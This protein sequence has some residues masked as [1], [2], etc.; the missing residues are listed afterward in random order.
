M[1]EIRVD[2][3]TVC[4]QSPCSVTKLA[5]GAH[6]VDVTAPGYVKSATRAAEIEY[7]PDCRGRVLAH[8]RHHG[9]ARGSARPELAAVRG[10]QGSR[11]L[12]RQR[13]RRRSRLAF[14]P[15]RGQRPLPAIRA[16]VNARPGRDQDARTQASGGQGRSPGSSPERTLKGAHVWLV[17]GSDPKV[18]LALPTVKEV[19]VDQGCRVEASKRGIR[20]REPGPLLRGRQCGEVIHRRSRQGQPRRRPRPGVVT[21]RE[22][23]EPAR[24]ATRPAAAP[25]PAVAKPAP[26][27][28]AGETCRGRGSPGHHQ[29][30][31]HARV[32]GDRG[33]NA[34]GQT[35]ARVYGAGRQSHGGVHPPP[36][37]PKIGDG[38]GQGR[39]KHR[40]SGQV[41][42]SP[43][44][45]RHHGK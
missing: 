33:R 45:R 19:A 34:A 15:H 28:A 35:P 39:R 2:D 21:R 12:A 4:R 9:R 16:A 3:R 24:K 41:R 17:C 10:W 7:R 38:Q 6:T 11:S 43:R 23:C 5:V 18:E 42:L 44:G 40:G 22:S 1:L 26:P 25:K 13:G 37:G 29:H 32:F 8:A 14:D 30:Q 36:E 27:P 20:E 31:L